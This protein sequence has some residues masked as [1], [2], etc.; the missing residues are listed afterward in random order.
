ML[1]NQDLD[2]SAWAKLYD[3]KLFETVQY[4]KGRLF[5]DSATTYK[6]I[7]LASKIVVKSESK[8]NYII[9]QS[10]ITTEE[11]SSKK[12]DLII[13]TQEMCDAINNKYPDLMQATNR[14]LM[15]A[16]LSTLTQL[17]KSKK[18]NPEIEQE[19]MKYIKSHTNEA[20]RDRNMPKRDKAALVALKFGT[21]F[22]KF[23][24]EIYEKI[25]GRK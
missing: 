3:K 21:G 1:Y 25:T 2:I 9:R 12:M 8:Y 5:E 20:L 13:S 14:R 11:F 10:S 23:V 22:Y 7:D 4:P 24:W 18:K 15:Y 16:Y 19:L 17:I 6:L